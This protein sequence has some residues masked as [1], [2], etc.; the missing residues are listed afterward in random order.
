MTLCIVCPIAIKHTVAAA[1]AT[2]HRRI[3]IVFEHAGGSLEELQPIYAMHRPFA[4]GIFPHERYSA[5][6]VRDA[7]SHG[8]VPMLHLPLESNNPADL[9]PVTGIVWVRMSDAQI[10]RV[11][12]D[13]LASG[14]GVVGVD[15]H[16]GSRATTDP[17]V[18][19]AALA[20]VK[21]HG[22]WYEEN[23][24]TSGSVATHV[25]RRLGVRTG[26]VT[27]YLD[28]PPARLTDN[29][30]GLIAYNRIY[31]W[32]SRG[33]LDQKAVLYLSM[34]SERISSR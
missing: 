1:S 14:P 20:V 12:E 13:D 23:I 30:R 3:A 31:Q 29:V 22:L 9:G 28:Q 8:L 7:R 2:G 6:I 4:L 10:T 25:A 32:R 24:E 26:Q 11:V 19:R 34:G 17:R 33:L 5:R 18:M 16:G 15:N 21:A 27:A